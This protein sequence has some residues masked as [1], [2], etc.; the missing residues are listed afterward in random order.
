MFQDQSFKA[1]NS[2][3]YRFVCAVRES[4]KSLA[5]LR[6][7]ESEA[8]FVED[9]ITVWQAGRATSAA[10]SFFDP[11]TIGE[12]HTRRAYVDGALGFN[13]PVDEVWAEAQDLWSPDEGN[14]E[15]M[16]KCVVSIGTGNP[17]TSAIGNKP[18]TIIKTLQ[19]I[20]TQTE[21]S[22]RMFAFN[23]RGLLDKHNVRYFR[24]NVEQGLQDVGLEEFDRHGDITNATAK[25]LNDHQT[26]KN[27]LR[28]CALNLSS[29]ECMLVEDFS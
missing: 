4:N 25:Y 22:E 12:G 15:P 7:Y 28:D 9:E 24:F 14:L 29:K 2:F 3:T 21:N 16:I 18:W 10:T 17:G 26:V 5:R 23:H 13:N 8:P 1:I 19:D 27:Q 20:A 6:S 11:I